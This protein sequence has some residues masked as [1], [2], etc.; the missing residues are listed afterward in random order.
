MRPRASLIEERYLFQDL[1]TAGDLF[2]FIQYKGGK[3]G[4]IEAAV[5]VRQVLMALD[6]LHEQNIAHRDLKPDNI[7]MTSLAD[8]SRVVLTD[9]G[10][11]RLAQLRIERMSTKIGTY[12]Y[13]AP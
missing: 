8:G 5:I 2:S 3:L 10:C 9:F 1:V 11:A 12:D 13:S 6:Y 4:D 7:L